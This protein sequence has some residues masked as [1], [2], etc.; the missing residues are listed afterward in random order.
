MIHFA[1]NSSGGARP[2]E[3]RQTVVETERFEVTGID[4]VEACDEG[5]GRSVVAPGVA[6]G[7]A[8][9]RVARQL[10]SRVPCVLRRTKRKARPTEAAPLP[11]AGVG[12]P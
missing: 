12:A 4:E 10:P 1:W 11:C 9:P 5:E 3:G 8:G 6:S 2:H 7:G